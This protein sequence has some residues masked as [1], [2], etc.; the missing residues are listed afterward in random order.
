MTGAF[1]R[2]AAPDSAWRMGMWLTIAA[3]SMMFTGLTSAYVVSQGLGPAWEQL[4]MR[5]LV[6]AD[7][8]ILLISSGTM[9]RARRGASQHSGTSRSLGITLLLGLLFLAGQIGVFR[10]LAQEGYYLNTGRQSSFFY[11]LT[12]LHGLHVI[13]GIL[14]LSF[15]AGKMGRMGADDPR[16]GVRMDVVSIYWHFMGVL[17]LWLLVVLFA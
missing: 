1:S 8:L 14:A 9:E 12:S 4:H 17:W 2:R 7:T 13:G 5:P 11:V 6:W 10:Q 3:S 16:R 15:V